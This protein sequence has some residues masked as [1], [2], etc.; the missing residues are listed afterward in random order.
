MWIF[1]WMYSCLPVPIICMIPLQE[2]MKMLM[3]KFLNY[4]DN[5]RSIH[6]AYFLALL[7]PASL[8]QFFT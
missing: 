1:Y 8:C 7:T 2:S 4:G 5:D 3:K 6:S